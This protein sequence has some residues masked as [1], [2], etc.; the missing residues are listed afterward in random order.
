V[1]VQPRLA[2]LTRPSV[3]WRPGGPAPALRGGVVVDTDAAT[4]VL[5]ELFRAVPR[6]VLRRRRAL[7]CV[8]SDATAAERAALVEAVLRAGARCVA[9]APEPLAAAFGAGIDLTASRVALL[10]DVGEGVTDCA[11]LRD[12]E[13]VASD[14]LRV[15]VA[16]L[17]A[18]VRDAVEACA[19]VRVS[20]VEA[21]R[22]LREIGVGPA[23]Q[24]AKVRFVG[25]PQHGAGP[26][27]ASLAAEELLD[28][29]DPVADQIAACVG[30]F[31]AS[32]PHELADDVRSGGICLTGGGALLAGMVERLVGETAMGVWRAPD[33]LR[34]V[35]DG[36]FSMV[37]SRLRL[38]T[39]H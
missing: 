29:L 12:T 6:S 39:W 26:V 21:E 30:R 16:D 28:A 14:A 15:G 22:L 34:A 32:L 23:A 4:A 9:V 13:V 25:S 33:P 24:P 31:V 17:R 8:P 2:P 19:N 36:A 18:A 1:H 35:I 7:A 27:R 38:P 10:V 3:V 20:L 11:L 5:E 37:A